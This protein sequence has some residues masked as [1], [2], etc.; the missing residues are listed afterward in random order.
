MNGQ[1]VRI[2]P[3]QVGHI[4]HPWLLFR[5]R[6]RT[7]SH[8]DKDLP[9][10]PLHSNNPFAQSPL[11][12]GRTQFDVWQPIF[13]FSTIGRRVGYGNPSVY[14]IEGSGLSAVMTL[15]DSKGSENSSNTNSKLDKQAYLFM[16]K[17]GM[18]KW[19]GKKAESIVSIKNK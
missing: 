12:D 14:T 10:T 5:P 7:G 17:H 9:D 18:K 4:L 19:F 15:N 2:R 11:D 8:R 6:K 13:L 3:K 1:W 16:K